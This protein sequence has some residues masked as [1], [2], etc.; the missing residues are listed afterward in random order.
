MSPMVKSPLTIELALLG[1][2][3]QRPMHAYEMHQ[4]LMQAEALGLVWHLKQSQLYALIARLEDE[5]YLTST[6]E[7]QDTRPPRKSLRL[8]DVGMAAFAQWL[9]TPVGHGR[10]FRLEFLAKLFFAS[11]E[12]AETLGALIDRQRHAC[13]EMITSLGMRVD[14]MGAERP[15]DRL[16]LQFR[17]GQLEATLHW[18]QQCEGAFLP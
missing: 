8:T 18:L 12:G 9:V 7:Q 1:F 16:V 3:R 14:A 6:I 15:Y 5:G 17:V 2:L 11:H 10:D 13:E 4:T